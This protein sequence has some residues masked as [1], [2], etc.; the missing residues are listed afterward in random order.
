MSGDSPEAI[1]NDSRASVGPDGQ[2]GQASI[3]PLMRGFLALAGLAGAVLLV[4]ATSATVIQIKVLTTPVTASGLDTKLSGSNRHGAALIVIAVF[5]AVMLFGA[6]RGAKPAMLAM[7]AA[8][9]LALGIAIIS[10]ARHIHDTGQ[11]GQLYEQ[12]SAGAG[13]GFRYETL[14]GALLIVAGGGLLFLAG[15]GGGGQRTDPLEPEPDP[16]T[17]EPDDWFAAT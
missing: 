12:A 14:G 3:V 8:G 2:A 6:L 13:P 5:A 15:G 1:P 4:L 7:A 11:V 17:P 9:L 16:R 10:D